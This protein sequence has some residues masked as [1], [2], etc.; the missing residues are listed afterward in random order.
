MSKNALKSTSMV[1]SFKL[2]QNGLTLIELLISITVGL[3]VVLAAT[4]LVVSTKKLFLSQTEGM[5][6]RIRRVLR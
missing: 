6:R 1:N 5:K 3:L 2:N 4:G